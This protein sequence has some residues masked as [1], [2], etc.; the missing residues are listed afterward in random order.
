MAEQIYYEDVTEG[1][2]IPA[3]EKVVTSRS[4]VMYCAAYEDFAEI[5][6]DKDAA[7]QAGFPGTVVPGL[8]TSA[9]LAQMLTDWIT[10][11]GGIRRLQANYRRPHFA[12]ETIVC[13]GRVTAMRVEDGER[14][15]ECEVWVENAE[16]ETSTTGSAVVVLP[17]SA[18][19]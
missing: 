8:F 2:T 10:P 6:H 1:M 18:T 19:G 9:F 7:Q 4:L 13:K 12:G 14:L 3:L 15:V 17:S 5:H 11:E 16:G